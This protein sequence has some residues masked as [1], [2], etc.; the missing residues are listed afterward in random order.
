MN[1][2]GYLPRYRTSLRLESLDR[3]IPRRPTLLHTCLAGVFLVSLVLNVLHFT[4]APRTLYSALDDYQDLNHHSLVNTSSISPLSPADWRGA[5][6]VTTLFSDAYAPA[7]LALG[8]SLRRTNTSAR[9]LLLYLPAQ[10]SQDALCIA[11][12]SGFVPHAIARIAPPAGRGADPHFV[13]QYT[14]LRLWTLDAL[15]APVT[16]AV[17]LDSDTLALQPLD[18]LFALPFSFGAVPDVWEAHGF[19]LAFNA[20][21]LVLRPDS[22]LFAQMLGKMG[23]ARFPRKYAEQAFLNQFFGADAARLPLAYNA[24]LAAKRRAPALWAALRAHVRVLHY[25]VVKPF[26]AHD[27]ARVPLERIEERVREAGEERGGEFREEMEVWGEVWGDARRVYAE[28][29]GECGM[30]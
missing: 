28:R 30:D 29:I 2:S 9:L 6:I 25:T 12:A 17:Y 26:V 10:V 27:W 11:T 20:G 4:T 22:A 24:N 19:T 5:A 1:L 13:D 8:H 7:V 18:A 3:S 21:V 16:R 14:K 23:E 15:P